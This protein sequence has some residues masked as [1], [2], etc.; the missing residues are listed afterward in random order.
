[1]MH[2]NV[3]EIL[4]SDDFANYICESCDAIFEKRYEKCPSC[5]VSG[6]IKKIE[7][8]PKL[9]DDD[10]SLFEDEVEEEE[11]HPKSASKMSAVDENS[12]FQIKVKK[13][14]TGIDGFD[15]L[16]DSGVIDGTLNLIIG[17]PGTGKTSF[18]LK[19]AE[20][21][22]ESG[23]TT[24]FISSEESG[25]QL[26]ARVQK[27]KIKSS[28]LFVSSISDIDSA[29]HEISSLKPDIVILDS[30]SGFFKK[31]I[32]AM[33]SSNIQIRE[34]VADLARFAKEK[35]AAVFLTAQDMSSSTFHEFGLISNFF[36]SMLAFEAPESGLKTLK[37]RKSRDS[38]AGK[39][40]VFRF[41]QDGA[42]CISEFEY[43]SEI[44]R[45]LSLIPEKYSIGRV[46]CFFIECGR[47]VY[48][49]LEALVG[50]RPALN[51]KW[52][53]GGGIKYEMFDS[54]VSIVEKYLNIELRD[55]N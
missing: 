7:I 2:Y 11:F 39:S 40:C 38:A 32:D 10:F 25:W 30:I 24:L 16:F 14:V 26:T 54:V 12:E 33:Q 42:R 46:A 31:N 23:C 20:L 8:I 28:R 34:C 4:N 29:M 21:Y 3:S 43:N 35:G 49:E 9:Y 51:P 45:R 52:N 19:I 53:V 15:A 44:V 41:E 13:Y 47:L 18:F 37:L 27:L 55:K 1:M 6:S 48:N 5:G 22:A 17:K 50:D 36:D